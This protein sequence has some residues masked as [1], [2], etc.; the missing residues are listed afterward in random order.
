MLPGLLVTLY[1]WL[2][3]YDLSQTFEGLDDVKDIRADVQAVG[4]LLNE[5]ENYP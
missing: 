2:G 3:L 4:E 1:S 5:T